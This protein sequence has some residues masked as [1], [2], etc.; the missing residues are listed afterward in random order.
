MCITDRRGNESRTRAVPKGYP[1]VSPYLIV[2][3]GAAA[4]QFYCAALGATVKR[5]LATKDGKIMHA[6][7]MIGDSI[8]MLAD[9]SSSHEA[10]GPEHFGGSPVSV[11]LYVENADKLYSRALKGGAVSLRPMADR[12]FGDRSGAIKD[13][14]GHRWTLAS[15]MENISDEEIE[16]RFVGMMS[17]G[18][19]PAA[20]EVADS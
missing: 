4:L 17:G 7:V 20:S 14:W 11:V 2:T 6:E 10:F 16:R 8:V 13:P 1:T 9:E 5:K 15:Q 12:P 18:G 19:N 3:N